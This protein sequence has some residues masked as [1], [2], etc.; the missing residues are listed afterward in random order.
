MFRPHSTQY[1]T[2]HIVTSVKVFGD[3][4]G[5]LIPPGFTLDY[6]SCLHR[7][8]NSMTYDVVACLQTLVSIPFSILFFKYAFQL[9]YS[10]QF[11]IKIISYSFL[12][13]TPAM[14]MV[15]TIR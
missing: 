2:T 3:D 8:Q 11:L 5:T 1:N 12:Q 14:E 13:I 10:Q 9:Y 6:I 15:T 7:L 4:L